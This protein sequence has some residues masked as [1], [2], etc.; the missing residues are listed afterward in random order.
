M[1][2]PKDKTAGKLREQY[3]QLDEYD[4]TSTRK[5]VREAKRKLKHHMTKHDRNQEKKAL[6][7]TLYSS[8]ED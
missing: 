2:K 1:S 8:T 6:R 4:T 7:Q 5:D 3:D